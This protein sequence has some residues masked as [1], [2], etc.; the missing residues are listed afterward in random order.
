MDEHEN[1][2]VGF[3]VCS[4]NDFLARARSTPRPLFG[5]LWLEGELSVLFGEPGCGKSLLAVQIA[6]SIASGNRLKRHYKA[7]RRQKVVY[8]DLESHPTQFCRRY[9]YDDDERGSK[10]YKFPANLTFIGP[11]AGAAA[12]IAVIGE[13]VKALGAK[14][15]IIDNI[16]HL[17]KNRTSTE[18][19]RVMHELRRLTRVDGISIL[20]L[21]HGMPG[22]LRR[23][24]EASDMPFAAVM[25][26]LA[27]NIFAIGHVSGD[28]AGRY[29][30]HIKPGSAPLTFG[31]AHVPWCR[32]KKRAN[33]TYFDF[34]GFA[35]EAVLRTSDNDR[36]EWQLI[37]RIGELK[38]SG[39]SVRD[40]G[41]VIEMSK[42]S[43]QRYLTMLDDDVNIARR[44]CAVHEQPPMDADF[45]DDEDEDTDYDLSDPEEEELPEL[46]EWDPEVEE[47]E[48]CR[49]VEDPDFAV[50]GVGPAVPEPADPTS[51]PNPLLERDVDPNGREI[52]V[53]KRDSNG[54]RL[55]WYLA[56]TNNRQPTGR[57][58]R[59]EH[60]G[61][62]GN[63][64]AIVDSL[65]GADR[66]P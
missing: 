21:V 18:A 33:F 39:M 55:V 45:E 26:G 41:R 14:V 61:L 34:R 22:N 49:T 58:T 5:D 3:E 15:L 6:D 40:I 10:L 62:G 16:G 36:R 8:V 30:K 25:T 47:D 65:P 2:A 27:D 56:E 42:S 24:I 4:M 13:R 63:I 38:D 32:I 19:A 31:A 11:A 9:D 44:R 1:K 28:P 12:D 66:G 46:P 52:F 51:T 17:M 53:E 60:R 48:S 59:Y 43:V 23:G 37:E 57:Y 7:P 29:I 64:G 20:L 50:F 35:R 54:R